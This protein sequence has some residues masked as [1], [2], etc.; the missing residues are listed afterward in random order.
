MKRKMSQ[1]SETHP[2]GGKRTSFVCAFLVHLQVC[3]YRVVEGA[4]L[5]L[6]FFPMVVYLE[7]SVI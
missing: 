5:V 1:N 4:S 7:L 6:F 3:G 2:R